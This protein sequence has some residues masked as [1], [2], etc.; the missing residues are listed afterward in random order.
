MRGI[1]GITCAVASVLVFGILAGSCSEKSLD[2]D[3]NGGAGNGPAATAHLDK[4]TLEESYSPTQFEKFLESSTCAGRLGMED[5]LKPLFAA[6]VVS[7]AADMWSMMY[8]ETGDM[9]LVNWKV[10][11]LN[12]DYHT[13]DVKGDSVVLSAAMFY[14]DNTNG[15]PGHVLES[16]SLTVHTYLDYDSD[17]PT[18]KGEVTMSRALWNSL[19]VIPDLQGFGSSKALGDAEMMNTDI[20]NQIVDCERVALQ[21]V[22]SRGLVM[23]DDY[24]TDILGY[25]LGTGPALG[26]AKW[27]EQCSKQD[28]EL[29]R[30]SKAFVGAGIFNYFDYASYYLDGRASCSFGELYPALVPT[31]P[32]FATE[33]DLC[34]YEPEDFFS[35]DYT[36]VMDTIDGH[37][38]SPA[39]FNLWK[40]D[41]GSDNDYNNSR[42]CSFLKG[43]GIFDVYAS[44][45]NSRI[46]N[47]DTS[48]PKTA[49]FKKMCERQSP[50]I[51]W[52]P[53][54]RILIF[55]GVNDDVIPYGTAKNAYNTLL[56]NSPNGVNDNVELL[57]FDVPVI[58]K[59]QFTHYTAVGIAQARMMT[60][61]DPTVGY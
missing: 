35:E 16:V 44:D 40:C 8:H 43:S 1:N 25:S 33:T 24:Y 42:T 41:E 45:M 34:G 11:R 29:F 54:H 17:R 13:V 50:C 23:A 20:A 14:P 6:F 59:F 38:F 2:A 52:C 39:T 48:L 21:I 19:V 7:R 10:V 28:R 22:K 53:K 27:M 9:S 3:G 60:F 31:I 4:I 55:Q 37:L 58:E 12:F 36:T 26:T 51:G 30:Y 18:A 47:L 49:A 61:K 5:Y 56:A 46:M 57:S 15:T 32:F